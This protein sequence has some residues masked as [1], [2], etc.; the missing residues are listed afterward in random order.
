MNDQETAQNK[1][2]SNGFDF[3][4]H[5]DPTI[6]YASALNGRSAILGLVIA[7]PA[8]T[9]VAN[10]RVELTVVSLQQPLSFPWIR[11]LT[12]LG[13]AGTPFIDLDIHW[14][15]S[16]LWNLSE[17]QPADIV[18][19]LV[20]AEDD[21]E[22]SSARW[23]IRVASAD[24]WVVVDNSS[25]TN[26][27]AF[28][29]PNHPALRQILD[30][31]V[32]A[33]PNDP[34]LSGYQNP[35]HVREM[36]KAIYEAV[37]SFELTYANPPASWDIAH[38]QKIRNPQ[39]I[40]E[41]RIGTC[42]DTAVLFASLLE[43]IGLYPLIAVVPGHAFV[44]YW[45]ALKGAN[46][47]FTPGKPLA[48]ISELANLFD[49]GEI[50]LFETTVVCKSDTITTFD[51]AVDAGRVN[52][53]ARG[54]LGSESRGSAF[55]DV[56]ATRRDVPRNVVPMP[57]RFVRPDG[58]VEVVEYKPEELSISLLIDRLSKEIA[59][60]KV[61]VN[62]IDTNVPPRLKKWL[63]SLLDLSLR[64]PLINFKEGRS[65]VPIV[66][67]P[68]S[69][70]VIEDMLARDETFRLVSFA[71]GDDP[72]RDV[73]L[74]NDRGQVVGGAP[75]EQLVSNALAKKEL[76]TKYGG[77]N[78]T[79]RLRKMAATAKTLIEETGSNG[80]FLSLGTLVWQPEGKAEVRSPLI[81]LPVNLLPK[82]RS[83]EF[84]ISLD[85][86]S[87]VTPNFS[88]A[89]KLKRDLGLK[90][91][92]LINLQE[93]ESGIDVPGTLT[94][95]REKLSE[96]GLAGFRVDEDA[97]LGFFN[98]STYRLWRDLIDNWR[99][100][101]KNPLVH[102]LM[103]TPNQPFDDPNAENAVADLDQLVAELPI[104]ADSSQA[105]AVGMALAGK[106][107]V[108]QGP[109]GTG[110]SQTITNMLARA[111][112]EGKRILFVAE[113][114]DAL[115]VVK[116]RLDKAG[117]GAFTLD[118]HDKGMSPKLV[119]EQLASVIDLTV[120]AD[121]VGFEAALDEYKNAL[122]PLQSYRSRLHEVGS[123]GES[124]YSAIDKMLAVSGTESFDVSG[125]FIA[126]STVADKTRLVEA[127]TTIAEI[128]PYSGTA[129]TNAWS[130]SGLDAELSPETT[131]E[132]SQL[133]KTLKLQ[134]D[135]LHAFPTAMG[136]LPGL[137]GL[138]ELRAINALRF[139]GV[140][141]SAIEAGSSVP[142]REARAFAH[143][144][145]T[146]LAVALATIPVDLRRL[147][148]LDVDAGIAELA[149]GRASFFLV[150]GSKV[151]GLIKRVNLQLG[152]KVLDKTTNL[153]ATLEQLRVIKAKQK[154]ADSDLAKV[155]GLRFDT[156]HTLFDAT[157]TAAAIQSVTE[158][159]QLIAFAQMEHATGI[160]PRQ[161]VSDVTQQ[162]ALATAL[163]EFAQNLGQ[164]FEKLALE[165]ETLALW[166]GET[167]L[168]HRLTTA[169]AE[170]HTD[171]TSHS[172]MQLVR[173]TRM[174]IELKPFVDAGLG[175]IQATV[176]SGAV[177]FESARNAFLKGYFAAVVNNLMVERGF[178]NFDG[179]AVN[180][181]VRKLDAAHQLLRQK[182][183]S[184]FGSQLLARR[185]FDSSMKIG[186]IGDL[187]MALN[188]KNS[189]TS[190]RSLLSKHWNIITKV[191]PCVLASP[192]STVRFIDANLAPFDIVIFDEASQIRVAN[193][194]G[195]IGR[196]T[197]AVVVGDT[198]QM[199]P[200]S[201]AQVRNV[202]DDD[203]APEDEDFQSGD[204]E[205]ILS[206]CEIAR[207]P[208][209]ML[210]WHYRSEDETLITYSNV[211][212]YKGKLNSFPAPDS[213]R[214]TKGLSLTYVEGGRFIRPGM[215]GGGKRGT[216][217]IEADA[218]IAEISR[219]LSDPNG[220]D[221]SLG[222]V[223]FNKE[224]MELVREKLI[225][226]TDPLIQK[227]LVEGVGGEEI[228]V[229]NL[230]TVQGSERDVILFSI[231]FSKNDKGDLP[232]NFGPLNNTGGERRLN[233]AITRARKQVIVF[234]SFHPAELAN[235][236]PTSV[237]LSH[238]SEFLTMA[239]KGPTSQMGLLSTDQLDLDRHRRSVV[240][241]LTAAGLTAVEE[242]GLSG[243]KVDIA[244]YDPSEPG[245][246]ILGL[247]LD[248]AR[249]NSRDTVSD[250]DTLP[251]AVLTK[252]MGWTAINRVWLPSWVTDPT[253]EVERISQAFEAAKIASRLPK[254]KKEPKAT[255]DA[256]GGSPATARFSHSPAGQS[257]A[258]IT[259]PTNGTSA[260]GATIGTT[261]GA[262]ALSSA[263]STT[264]LIRPVGMNPFDQ[265]LAST[266][267]WEPLA[268]YIA[269]E[270]GTL[271]YLYDRQV[272]AGVRAM[273]ER[274]TALEGPV[275]FDRL[276]KFVASCFGF[277]RVVANRIEDINLMGYPGHERDAEGFIYP[278]GMSLSGF[279]E[280]RKGS[281][282]HKRPL[283]TVS[284]GEIAN[285]LVDITRISQG[286][287]EEQLISVAANAL[288]ALKVTASVNDRMTAALTGALQSG[289]LT[290]DEEHIRVS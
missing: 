254:P 143:Q 85:D 125:E 158:L 213:S 12:E 196:A 236:N 191:T 216:N 164:L 253:G 10:V 154:R 224:Q 43:N 280:W 180:S 144:S 215:T 238:L 94:H 53:T 112:H 110:K 66:T 290:R 230:E 186:A 131:A 61:T 248:G 11:T 136:Y 207:V 92:N 4:L 169:I 242:V 162:P 97:V 174:R 170:W 108:L 127:L 148:T 149:V 219:R 23:P 111:L 284:L 121:T 39:T 244:L 199:P 104:E 67:A 122:V 59:D 189:R 212:Y 241:A 218:I 240:E 114:K 58:T 198:K 239:E 193:S 247:L 9:P 228:F 107:F 138:D 229:K 24:S 54:I 275:S 20:N 113:K 165:A 192:D 209:I 261:L 90:L 183:P 33:M 205:S 40:L 42:L 277:N 62:G 98:F 151:G 134:W 60:S 70:G 210:N 84:F 52:L 258:T 181:F 56:V 29:Q 176:L 234:T 79:A 102:H 99:T 32:S 28:V 18:V 220:T 137:T 46:T 41:E 48:R 80:L 120:D 140:S 175:S 141:A 115:D 172:L 87:P 7:K 72:D 188:Q 211:K 243:F 272:Q 214:E 237:G 16:E 55:I 178:N 35:A 285:A 63:D 286:I 73:N 197:A 270:Q 274:L 246:A 171:A 217:T 278:Q 1:K 74:A 49:L 184:I 129:P 27:G 227:A 222:V 103:Y 249:W 256:G 221:D 287:R 96:A 91:D 25:Y 6:Y 157:H 130:L 34:T 159:D 126:N 267:T 17:E 2:S 263:A 133:A 64:N 86:S 271:D 268:T 14:D 13:S 117:L 167:P 15:A 168:G 132:I 279:S 145:L 77:D 68:G 269:G 69:L 128:G 223:T 235:K 255:L 38:G 31:A 109:P 47:N 124:V 206:Q 44:G 259:A 266:P 152:D 123:L 177:T 273:V 142:G 147:A 100:F 201:V 150:R 156:E 182:L 146:E 232:L 289:K 203:D 95:I 265:L 135:S 45:T 283:E 119:R 187:I 76:V 82:N 93:D 288:G 106:T 65:A 163:V 166:S 226:S 282:Q 194:L 225:S 26:L 260:D 185:G 204:V 19:R 8:G 81:L 155:T 37:Q 50:E 88:L 5:A 36:V 245:K 233:V 161:V 75:L 3:D 21:T 208:D 190:V 276:G 78:S 179:L 22:L 30:R 251:I 231:A 71:H 250:R 262:T 83:R 51:E 105:R 160:S 202:D 200:T 257:P 173:W 89:E 264:V 57:A 252:K 139:T 101:E 281:D 195:A 153:E 118:L 116:D